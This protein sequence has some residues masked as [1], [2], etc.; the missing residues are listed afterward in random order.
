MYHEEK[1][2]DGG[3]KKSE[4]EQRIQSPPTGCGVSF[5]VCKH[6]DLSPDALPIAL[7]TEA[8]SHKSQISP[9]LYI[10]VLLLFSCTFAYKIMPSHFIRNPRES[11]IPI[12]PV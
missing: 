4:K 2:E 6:E 1:E 8:Q 9:T 5:C 10:F 7:F 11:E 3:E 12:T